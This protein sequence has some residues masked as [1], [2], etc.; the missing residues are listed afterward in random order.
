[1]AENPVIGKAK[2]GKGRR[3]PYRLFF[4]RVLTAFPGVTLIDSV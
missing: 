3:K 4:G 2:S 1:M